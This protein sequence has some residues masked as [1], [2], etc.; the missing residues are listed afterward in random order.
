MMGAREALVSI[1]GGIHWYVLLL[2]VILVAGIGLFAKGKS[3]SK[4]GYTIIEE[5]P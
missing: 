2:G 5:K 1:M 3:S 4:S